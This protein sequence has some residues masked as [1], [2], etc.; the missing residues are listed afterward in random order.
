MAVF[1]QTPGELEIKAVLGND[2]LCSLNF[3]T[4]IAAYDFTAGIILNEYP[5]KK[6]YPILTTK[7]SST[8]L[9]LQ[10]S[11][12]ST[13][14]IG[15]ISNKKW[16]LNWTANDATQT[17]LSGRF[18]ISDVP[19]GLNEG[20]DVDVIVNFDDV[21][22][23]VS[24]VASFGATGA[25]GA[26]GS[27]GATGVGA[28]GLTGSTGATGIGTLFSSSPPFPIAG[29]NWVD[30]DTMRFYQ[31]YD[32]AWVET[33]SS[34]VGQAG[35]TGSGATGAT[36]VTGQAGST[37]ATG[38]TGD[39]GSTGP[40]G[41]TGA[42]GLRGATG[43]IGTTGATGATGPTG[44]QGATGIGATGAT[45]PAGATGTGIRLKGS[46]ATTL[47][48][49]LV[50]NTIGD[51]YIVIADGD[52]YAWSGAQWTNVGQIQGPAGPTG[53][54]GIQG[55]TGPQGTTGSTGLTGSTGSTGASGP[56]GATGVIGTTGAT[57]A[58]GPTG[59]QG[60]TGQIGLTGATG[61]QGSTGPVG[62][63]GATG[64]RVDTTISSNS[65]VSISLG[66]KIFQHTT[67]FNPVYTVGSRV[68]ITG[69]TDRQMSG[70]VT[71]VTESLTQVNVDTII[72]GSG[73]FSSW[74]IGLS[75]IIGATGLVGPT[76]IQ[77]AT[78]IQG[79]RGSTGSTGPTGAT[80]P[81]GTPGG[82]TGPVGPTGPQGATG[83]TGPLPSVVP[84][85]QITGEANL[86]LI[87]ETKT[88]TGTSGNISLNLSSSTFFVIDRTGTVT[89]TFSSPPASPK[90]FSFT[91]FTTS[92]GYTA[93]LIYPA[94]VKWPDGIPPAL[95][96]ASGKADIL[97]FLTHDG[98][99]TWFGFVS[100]QNY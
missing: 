48:L 99:N 64:L 62:S 59:I 47:D 14:E 35:A 79:Q 42:T 77:G 50:G 66:G 95:S 61:I 28:T 73:N 83:A 23:N 22:I 58:T 43:T 80:G 89:L 44:P 57:G 87:T 72:S 88:T 60:A 86:G 52:G 3:D 71:N 53:A 27:T 40:I 92:P 76:G 49:P 9:N 96:V 20:N 29:L 4:S 34:F 11:A 97:S 17:I 38:A 56:V 63:T 75:S 70:T 8:K 54:T 93:F 1:S 84:T 94:S 100:G 6:I 33:S 55:S 24:S 51:L 37:G 91:I 39:I 2:F 21:N 16:F 98:G 45:G 18:Q 81:Q 46:V 78:G 36:G 32:N 67:T 65:T 82:A 19:I 68:I 25:T 5:D 31:Y 12:L 13:N 85:L 15:V 69:T 90:V 41:R 10:L 26:A 7:A 30:T 74:T